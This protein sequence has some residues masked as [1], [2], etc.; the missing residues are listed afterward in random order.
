MSYVRLEDRS[1]QQ[2]LPAAVD[3]Y[4][5][6][7][8]PL[9]ALDQFVDNLPLARLGFAVAAD[10]LMSQGRPGIHPGTLL[11]LYLWG[12]LNRVRSSRRLERA[13][14]R[15]L[16]VIWL[17][18]NATP[19]HSTIAQ[20]RKDNPKALKGVFKQFNLLCLEVGLF[21][22]ELVALDGTFIKAVNSRDRSFTKG[23]LKRRLESIGKVIEQWMERL[24]SADRAEAGEEVACAAGGG[25]GAGDAA[26]DLREKIARMRERASAYESLLGQ[27][28][29]SETGQVNLTD[30]DSRQLKKGDK[31][32]VGYNV[33]A[34]VEGDNH[35]VVSCEVTR[36]ATD[37]G[38]LNSM[39]QQAKE[40]LG[41]PADAPLAV[42][43][44]RGYESSVEFAKCEANGTRTCVA[45]QHKA[46]PPGDGSLCLE[47]F[48]HQ[49]QEDAY[50]C[51]AGELLHR[52]SDV[53]SKNGVVYRTYYDV[54]ACRGCELR[55]RCTKGKYR[56]LHIN[57][58]QEAVDANLMRLAQA[59]GSHARRRAIAEHPFGTIKAD[60]GGELL[61]RGREL[62]AAETSLGFWAYNF[63]RV[64]KILGFAGLMAMVTP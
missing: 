18:Q 28:E 36:D 64:T 50:R 60:G 15:N 48:T 52:K 53:R 45:V 61:C 23:K 34:A 59:P 4:I 24:E 20:F 35:L 49:A 47:A 16:E 37:R 19:D 44:D 12:Y 13:C 58:N 54:S 21:S 17:V 56:K 31:K 63:K 14:L 25:S 10:T 39:A 26:A 43:A 1:Q 33:Q 51:P 22:R 55:G 2:L 42:L 7:D 6:A 27:C 62:A 3:D 9:R 30:P 29:C 38:Q 57:E 11:K 8:N 46:N 32:T 40:D 5:A 41:L